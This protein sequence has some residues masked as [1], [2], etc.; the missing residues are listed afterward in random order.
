MIIVKITD[1]FK[2]EPYTS[3]NLLYIIGSTEKIRISLSADKNS[4]IFSVYSISH[5]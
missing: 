5:N 1:D 3:S 4:S 2:K